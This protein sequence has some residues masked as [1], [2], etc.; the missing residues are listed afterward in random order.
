VVT[1]PLGASFADY[2]GRAHSL[3]G[4]G[5]GSGRVAVIV[6]IA[7]AAGVGYLSVTRHD[8]QRADEQAVRHAAVSDH[9]VGR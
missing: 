3:S 5:F 4:A 2:F 8:I 6:A 9:V 1:R 7:V